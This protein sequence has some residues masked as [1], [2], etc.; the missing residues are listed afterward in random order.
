M[1]GHSK[2]SKIKRIKAVKDVKKGSLLSRAS[3]NITL[4]AHLGGGADPLMNPMLRVAIDYARSVNMAKDKIEKAVAKGLG[5]NSEGE[6][7]VEKTYE[8]LGPGGS[9]FLIDTQTDSPNRTYTDLKV[10]VNRNG[11]KMVPEDSFAWKFKEAGLIKCEVNLI[12]LAKLANNPEAYINDEIILN[13]MELEGLENIN[14]YSEENSY[15]I[16]IFI[17]KKGLREFSR[18]R[19]VKI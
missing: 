11:G 15:Y 14:H 10:I 8:V 13:L 18:N 4:A 1:S 5:K 19:L 12:N 9:I 3:R 6:D 16:E 2:W 17:A 7:S